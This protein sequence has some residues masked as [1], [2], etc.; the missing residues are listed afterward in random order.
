MPGAEHPRESPLLENLIGWY[1]LAMGAAFVALHRWLAP[2][3]WRLQE[4]LV[5]Q[6]FSDQ[7]VDQ[8]DRETIVRVFRIAYLG[9]GLLFLVVGLGVFLI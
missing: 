7:A 8:Y 5:R 6:I 1:F 4:A 3:S 2:R 9:S